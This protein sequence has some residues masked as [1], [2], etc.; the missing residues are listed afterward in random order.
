MNQGIHI[1]MK[2]VAGL[3][4]RSIEYLTLIFTYIYTLIMSSLWAECTFPSLDVGLDLVT[5]F[6]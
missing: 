6:D 2:A 5:S 3:L 4:V 1:S